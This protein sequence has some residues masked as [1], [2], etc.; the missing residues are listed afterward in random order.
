MA[1]IRLLEPPEYTEEEKNALVDFLLALK[2]THIQDFFRGIELPRSG[3]KAELRES[4]QE[5]LNEGHVTHE[6]VVD[7][8]DAV[9]PWGKQHVFLYTG[10]RSGL[11]SWKDPD[12]LLQHLKRH[13]VGKYFNAR[14]PLIL[15]ERLTLS[16]ITHSNQILRI[17]AVQKRG[18]AERVPEY[19]DQKETDDG[20]AITLKA[21][22]D[23]VSRT[24]V[25]FE[26][27]LTSNTAMLQITQLHG[28]RLYEQVAKEFFE[29]V[30]NW[31]D[32]EKAF[33]L[34][35]IRNAIRRLHEL[36]EKGRG[37]ARSHGIDYRT[38]GNRTLAARSPSRRDSVLGEP[39][40]DGAM[41][42][43]RR[44]GVGHFGNF[45]WLANKNPGVVANPLDADVHVI[46]VGGKS[47]INFPTPNTE[48]VVRYVLHRV[49]ALS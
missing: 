42:G 43:M 14:L 47:R 25:A 31:L 12:L 36:E 38:L 19:D 5:A 23:H 44:E 27:N 24:L 7:F 41:A 28:D 9:A 34:V 21:Y 49:R 32:I 15:P 11:Q 20:T 26:W 1:S 46:L 2:K 40:V 45:Y 6:Q 37:E 8:L 17:T 10:P 3:T 35:D 16:S 30:G 13:R 48:G 29:L 39:V 22:I 4:L 33:V 18:Y